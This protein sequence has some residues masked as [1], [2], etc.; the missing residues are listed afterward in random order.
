MDPPLQRVRSGCAPLPA[1][2]RTHPPFAPEETQQIVDTVE[3]SEPQAHGLPGRRWTLKKL[4]LWLG[5]K[6]QRRVSKATLH[7][8]LHAA[9]LTWKKCK[10]LLGKGDPAK[11][12]VF[13]ERFLKLYDEVVRGEVV[14]IYID[15]SH[16]HRDLEN[17]YL[18][19]RKGKAVWRWSC[20]APLRDRINWYGAYNFSDGQCLIWNEGNCC[21]EHT[22][23]FLQRVH[24]WLV[25]AGRRIVVIWDNASWHTAGLVAET[26]E[27]LGIELWP[28]PS[29]SPD[30]NAIEALW[31]WM[32]EEVTQLTCYDT[33]RGL[34]DACKR[35]V[36][37]INQNPLGIVKRLWPRFELDPEIEKLR[38]SQ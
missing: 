6:F 29:Y 36:E 10:K 22:V 3:N 11:R 33:L 30:F 13:V 12:A 28:L 25:P 16:F 9:G 1:H 24:D 15:E 18:W 38:F 34:F 26:A 32:R 2:G 31:K 5:E 8:L 35:F 20:C 37:E 27:K 21:K 19:G 7:K 17:G 4:R 14:L 23:E